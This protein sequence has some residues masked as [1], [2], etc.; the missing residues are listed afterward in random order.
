MQ[1]QKRRIKPVSAQVRDLTNALGRKEAQLKRIEGRLADLAAEAKRIQGEVSEAERV[2][3]EVAKGM[4]D[5]EK[6][7]NNTVAMPDPIGTGKDGSTK[8]DLPVLERVLLS[9]LGST[10]RRPKRSWTNAPW[11]WTPRGRTQIP[12]G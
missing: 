2:R 3:A 5:I 12:R 11:R 6:E 8:I 1:L 10:Q 9:M 4:S 7:R